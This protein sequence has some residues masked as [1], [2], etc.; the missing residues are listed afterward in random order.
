MSY[1]DGTDYAKDHVFSQ[2]RLSELTPEDLLRWMNIKTYGVAE[3]PD[4]ANP[5]LAR[6]NSIKFW[7]K[8]LSHFM[9]N[10]LTPWNEL[11]NVG[12]PTRSTLINKL[13]KDVKKKE[14]WKQ[15]A[16]SQ[17]RRSSAIAEF[18]RVRSILKEE[19]E[20]ILWTYGIPAMN[21]YQ[22]HMIGRIDDTTQFQVENLQAHDQFC[23]CLKSKLAWSKNVHEERDA[24]WQ[25]IIGAMD[26][27]FCV[28]VSL[29]LWLEVYIATDPNALQTPYVFAFSEDNNVPAGGVKSKS[30][31]QGIFT[32]EIFSRN[33][34]NTEAGPLGSHSF[35]KMASSEARKRGATKDE[36]D[37]R[38]R[39][40]GQQR[41]SDVYDD[42][43]MPFP[44]AKVAGLLCM[45]GPC[46]YEIKQNSGISE[47]FLLTHVVPNVARRLPHDVS[48]VLGTALMWYVFAPE[49][50]NDVPQNIRDRVKNAYVT[51]NNQ[52]EEDDNPIA[53]IPLVITGN[54]GEVYMDAIPHDENGGG[55]GDGDG[56]IGNGG[57]NHGGQG[58]AFI[59]RP[60]RQQLLAV[61]S[62]ILSVRQSLNDLR[63]AVEQDRTTR[64]RQFRTLN[65]NVRRM[66]LQPA[67]RMNNGGNGDGGAAAGEQNQEQGANGLDP[68]AT[69]SATPRTLYDLWQEYQYGIGTRKP[70]R[71]FTPQERGRS[72]FKYSRRKV[73]WDTI[74]VLV[75]SGVT[76]NVAMDRIYQVYGANS[77][78]TT[79]INHLRQDKRDGAL[80]P[81]L[82]G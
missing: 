10:K 12:N 36:K 23:F 2:Q 65:T 47:Q 17:A 69:L 28:L 59:N 33:E 44:D 30:T 64:D 43:E 61:H 54:E 46:K 38:G 29:A 27:S 26:V 24:P 67:R 68:N 70:A 20:T 8:S 76:A 52:L 35:R 72:K 37:I 21:N 32:E 16:P 74:S 58:G 9:P 55:E 31:V 49:G 19:G 63:L 39:W 15:G 4:D 25:V 7:K 53:K 82:Q 51:V 11:A 48:V 18:R 56:G 57:G 40:K 45:G 66:A 60:T 1:L 34:F 73:V 79:I 77:T 81:L 80:H 42:V 71:L 6:S 3:P 75:R 50:Q 22:V 78:V 14:V 41:V 13:I 62:Q 5:T